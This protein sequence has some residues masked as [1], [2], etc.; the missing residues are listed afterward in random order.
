MGNTQQVTAPL[1]RGAT[2]LKKKSVQRSWKEWQKRHT[3]TNFS[4][5]HSCCSVVNGEKIIEVENLWEILLL[6]HK[7]LFLRTMEWEWWTAVQVFAEVKDGVGWLDNG[8]PSQGFL[9]FHT[10]YIKDDNLNDFLCPFPG[11]L[12][13]YTSFKEILMIHWNP[14]TC[15]N[16]E[17]TRGRKLQELK[18]KSQKHIHVINQ[19]KAGNWTST[20]WTHNFSTER[21]PSLLI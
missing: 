6:H 21:V 2:S 9:L 11:Y 8:L 5:Q 7:K 20:S 18:L 16:S 12:S 13:I 10:W 17:Y 19:V 1:K 14:S 4:Q 15:R 3:E